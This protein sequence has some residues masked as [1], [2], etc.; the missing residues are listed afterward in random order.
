M[1]AIPWTAVE[2]AGSILSLVGLALLTVAR[3]WVRER[4]Y[5]LLRGDAA[6]HR[7]FVLDAV[8]DK[9]S[10]SSV[11]ELILDTISDPRYAARHREIN[12][13]QWKEEIAA[14]REARALALDR[15]RL[16]DQYITSND[17][18]HKVSESTANA[19]SQLT[20]SVTSLLQATERLVTVTDDIASKTQTNSERL[21]RLEGSKE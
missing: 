9:E 16:L 11:A 14:N 4:T 21:A 7:S 1:P 13:Q 10:R 8:R 19:V 6:K 3:P 2:T 18:L 5:K 20:S 17:H 15:S 12:A